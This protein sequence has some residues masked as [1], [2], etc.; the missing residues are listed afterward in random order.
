MEQ[1]TVEPISYNQG[2]AKQKYTS[3]D[4]IIPSET[5]VPIVLS[6]NPENK[7]TNIIDV[8]GVGINIV[9][10]GARSSLYLYLIRAL[11]TNERPTRPE[12]WEMSSEERS[13]LMNK[14]IHLFRQKGELKSFEIIYYPDGSVDAITTTQHK[15][16]GYSEV[17]NTVKE[18][19]EEVFGQAKFFDRGL[20]RVAT[21]LLPTSSQYVNSWV[22]IDAG[23]NKPKG[24]CAVYVYTRFEVTWTGQDGKQTPCHN[25]AY[26]TK[27]ANFFGIDLNRIPGIDKYPVLNNLTTKAIH[28]KGTEIK[29]DELITTLNEIKEAVKGIDP[30]I[31]DAMNAPLH[32]DEMKA[33]LMAYE[34]SIGLPKYISEQIVMNVVDMNLWGLSNAVSWVRTHGEFK[35]GKIENREAKPII[36]KLENIAGELLTLG[37]AIKAIKAKIKGHTITK[38]VLLNPKE[39][40]FDANIATKLNDTSVPK[41]D[42]RGRFVKI[43]EEIFEHHDQ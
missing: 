3:K 33:I 16:I 5:F 2:P 8:N 32:K 13:I 4:G 43:G 14:C 12:I 42:G 34:E 24:R 22:G 36:G 25:W 15:Q 28:T 18:T 11:P 9:K 1:A 29:K 31:E 17:M 10:K 38:D 41:R 40:M 39:G 7:F 21:Y 35:E 37:P 23:V 26:W 19:V 27:P 20:E 6:E 30:I